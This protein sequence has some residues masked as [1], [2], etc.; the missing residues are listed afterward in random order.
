[1]G[2]L[3]PVKPLDLAFCRLRMVQPAARIVMRPDFETLGMGDVGVVGGKNAS[4]GEM[5]GAL[6]DSGIRVPGGFATTADAYR[7]FLR[8]NDLEEPISARLVIAS[9]GVLGGVSVALR[10]GDAS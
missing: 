10:G 9:I 1:M 2:L 5:I 8:Y 6:T 3:R 4:L 7:A